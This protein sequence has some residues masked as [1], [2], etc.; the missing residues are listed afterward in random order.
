MRTAN[1]ENSRIMQEPFLSDRIIGTGKN[2]SEINYHIL[3]LDFYV[4]AVCIGGE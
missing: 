2:V 3:K 1:R 4:L